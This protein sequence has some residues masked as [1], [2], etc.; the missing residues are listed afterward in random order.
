MMGLAGFAR[1]PQRVAVCFGAFLGGFFSSDQH[2]V[3]LLDCRARGASDPC[4]ELARLRSALEIGG[5]LPVKS[6]LCLQIR[7]R[8]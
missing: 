4:H 1:R 6:F 8:R 3:F 2:F 7:S 5:A